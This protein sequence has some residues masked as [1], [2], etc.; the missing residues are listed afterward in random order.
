MSFVTQNATVILF[1]GLVYNYDSYTCVLVITS[2]FVQPIEEFYWQKYR[3]AVF[4]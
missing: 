1:N 2:A 3:K 4:R